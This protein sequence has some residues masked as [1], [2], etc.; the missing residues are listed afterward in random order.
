M[1]AGGSARRWQRPPPVRLRGPATL[2]SGMWSR[3]GFAAAVWWRAG[4]T[5]SRAWS[6]CSQPLDRAVGDAGGRELI[7][8][9]TRAEEVGLLGASAAA[10][11]RLLPDRCRRDRGRN[12]IV[13]R[14]P[15][16]FGRGTDRA[17]GDAMHLFSPAVALWITGVAQELAREDDGFRFQRRLMDG[18]VT[19]ATAYDLYGY[20]TG[21]L[22]IALANYHNGGP[23]GRVA[24]ESV[25]LGDL[26][27]LVRLMSRPA[28]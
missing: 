6:A 9:F 23:G 24:A 17:V 8:L 13:V 22:C 14:R 19:E 15:R 18:G 1:S 16:A 28:R 21:A 11:A 25:D 7:G 26:E 5:T 20:E 12:I 3:C 27:G 2:R 4:A 10:R